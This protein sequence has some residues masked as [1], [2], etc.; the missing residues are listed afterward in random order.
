MYY[1]FRLAICPGKQSLFDALCT[2]YKTFFKAWE[3][4]NL[5]EAAHEN[6]K[7]CEENGDFDDETESFYAESEYITKD[8]PKQVPKALAAASRRLLPAPDENF[9]VRT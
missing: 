4:E 2:T 8:T 7:G 1:I 6:G 5:S 9:Q 3:W